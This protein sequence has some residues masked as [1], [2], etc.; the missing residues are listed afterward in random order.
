MYYTPSFTVVGLYKGDNERN[1]HTARRCADL[2]FE[3]GGGRKLQRTAGGPGVSM[4]CDTSMASHERTG[5]ES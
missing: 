4:L 5:N 1:M 3:A 2:R